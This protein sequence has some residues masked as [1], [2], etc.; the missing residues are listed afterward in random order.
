MLWFIQSTNELTNFADSPS[1]IVSK[2]T[3]MS[4]NCLLGKEERVLRSEWKENWIITRVQVH[5]ERKETYG[6]KG[7]K[8]SGPMKMAPEK[9]RVHPIKQSVFSLNYKLRQWVARSVMTVTRKMIINWYLLLIHKSYPLLD[10][11]QRKLHRSGQT[12]SQ[13]KLVSIETA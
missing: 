7:T 8:G 5:E 9:T 4:H 12:T 6:S 13:L 1:P 2:A 11:W 3:T 10:W